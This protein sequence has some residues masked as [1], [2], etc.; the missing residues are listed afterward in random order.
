MFDIDI[1]HIASASKDRTRL[2]DGRYF[3]ISQDTGMELLAWLESGVEPPKVDEKLLADHMAAI[4]GADS[5]DALKTAF[6]AAYKAAEQIKDSHAMALFSD[7]KD[8]RKQE[9]SQPQGVN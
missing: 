6:A 2:F 9:L 7:A 3:K 8:V 5:M 1:N 4:E